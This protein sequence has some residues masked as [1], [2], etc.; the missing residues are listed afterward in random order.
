METDLTKYDLTPVQKK[1]AKN[2]VLLE[3]FGTCTSDENPELIYNCRTWSR[4][5]FC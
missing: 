5:I 4:K 1:N 2:N 3:A